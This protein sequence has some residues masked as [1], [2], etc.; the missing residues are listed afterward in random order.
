MIRAEELYASLLAAHGPQ[1]WWP[2]EDP[3]E[4]ITGALLVQRTAWS[5]AALAVSELKRES[6]LE[7]AALA[8]ADLQVVEQTIR[9]AGFFRTKAGRLKQLARF[10]MASGGIEGLERQSTS[11]LRDAL[12]RLNG[13]GPETADTILLYAFSRPVVVVDEYLR[14]LA[15]RLCAG[16]TGVEDTALRRWISRGLSDSRRLN[17]MHA[18]VVAHGKASCRRRPACST[19]PLRA[20]CLTG[21][22][23]SDA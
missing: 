22:S 23:V 11:Q 3:F 4:I 6:L 18:L 21:R 17:E 10:V 12:L 20:L 16:R 5:N 2:A 14:R 19:C 15:E 7:P 9:S 13:I 8:D 1:H